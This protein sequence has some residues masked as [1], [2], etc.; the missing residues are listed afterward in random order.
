V[1]YFQAFVDFLEI[2]LLWDFQ[3]ERREPLKGIR[4]GGNDGSRSRKILGA[5]AGVPVDGAEFVAGGAVLLLLSDGGEVG[6]VVG[7]SHGN[8]AHPE[9]G[10]GGVVVE[11]RVVLGVSVDEVEG[12]GVG[13]AGVLDVAEEAAEDGQLEGVE[14]EGKRRRGGDGVLRGVGVVELDGGEGVGSGVL[15]P[16]GDVGLGD[17]G[18][19]FVELDAFDAQEWV[20]RGE[21]AG[22]A[23]AGANVEEDGLFDGSLGVK[24]LQPAV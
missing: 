4:G 21:E 6:D 11:E 18:E 9:A 8:A 24:L 23:F 22:A 15:G 3:G 19:G 1:L 10:E 5:A 14:E 7:R 12:R 13:G 16:E 17:V 2:S 20:L